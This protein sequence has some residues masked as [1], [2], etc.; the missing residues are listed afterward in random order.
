M[1]GVGVFRCRATTRPSSQATSSLRAVARTSAWRKA[2]AASALTVVAAAVVVVDVSG[3]GWK[4]EIKE[5][6]MMG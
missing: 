6:N 3:S 2:L 4:Y 1:V 5:T